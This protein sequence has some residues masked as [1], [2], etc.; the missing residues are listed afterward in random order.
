LD[1]DGAIVVDSY[2]QSSVPSVWAI[3]D[4][5]NRINLTP[6]AI[7]EG[8]CLV[9]TLFGSGPT[10]PDH[11]DVPSAIFSQPP[12]GSVGLIEED[13]RARYA[14]IDV[15]RTSFRELKH[16]LSGRDEET[17]MKLIVDRASDRVVGAHMLG[18]HAAEV[19][20][21]I[22]IAIKAGATKAQFDSTLGIHP[23]SA[24]EFVTMRDPVAD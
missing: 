17:T 22:A 18:A 1:A 16:T 8:M 5:T 12:I 6:V 13:A 7:E 23:T 20:Q 3:G 19:I 10:A 11:A 24:E 15:Y 14:E 9:E 2:S 21:G 4:V